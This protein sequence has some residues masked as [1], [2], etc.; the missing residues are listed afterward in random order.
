MKID[1]TDGKRA[2]KLESRE[3]AALVKAREICDELAEL[4]GDSDAN[5]AEKS[6]AIVVAKFP[7]PKKKADATTA[8]AGTSAAE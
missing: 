6:L 8:A 1:R 2:V 4:M 3:H 7:A 5:Q